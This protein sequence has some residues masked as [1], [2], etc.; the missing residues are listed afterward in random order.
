MRFVATT[1]LLFLA[2]TLGI[3]QANVLNDAANAALEKAQ[4]DL[5]AARADRPALA[6]AGRLGVAKLEDD[7]HGITPL[8]RS[9]L[10]RTEFD[11]VLTQ[12]ADWA[13]LVD[14]FARQVKRQDIIVAETAHELRVQGVDAVL[15]GTVQEATVEAAEE[16]GQTGQRAQVRLMIEIASLAEE[17]PGSLLWSVQVEGSAV[18]LEPMSTE[19]QARSFFERNRILVIVLA[20]VIGI[21]V[22]YFL[23]RRVTAPR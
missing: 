14:E 22:L 10:T 1:T 7:T 13:P 8:V 4:A 23:A 20:V 11:V 16:G 9:M 15:F 5:E 19:E 12:D 18:D 2:A 3:A 17:N 21:G 6:N